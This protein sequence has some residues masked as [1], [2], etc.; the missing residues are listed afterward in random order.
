MLLGAVLLVL[1]VACANVANMLLTRALGRGRELATRAALGAGPWRL[2]AGALA[3][4][5]A[6]TVLGCALGLGVALAGVEV[7]VALAPPGLPRIDRIALDGRALGFAFA[8]TLLTGVLAGAMPALIARRIAVAEA[9]RSGSKTA[10]GGGRHAWRRSLVAAELALSV[11]LLVGATLMIQSLARLS[12]VDPGFP[13]DH[14]LTGRITLPNVPAQAD[15][16]ATDAEQRR[17]NVALLAA[18]RAEIATLPGVVSVGAIDSLPVSG[19]ANANGGVQIEGR[20]RYPPGKEPLVEF[21]A[22]SSG[23]FETMGLV[24]VKGEIFRD[25]IPD[26]GPFPVVVNEALVE[27]L[28]PGEEPLG[29][30][31]I[32]T[33]G[34]PH[35]IIGVVRSAKQWGLD[36][37]GADPELYMSYQHNAWFNETHL[38]IRTLA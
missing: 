13:T 20:D 37:A 26:G 35:P 28:F 11:V 6:L 21:R 22:V 25:A 32:A 27:R 15:A 7:L 2:G 18:L 17:A 19:D 31:I 5:L 29:R 1:L 34:Q 33:D 12:A 30:R 23:Y 14:L 8:L 9:L 36:Q 24:V 10:S 4:S 38:V 3:E 16:D